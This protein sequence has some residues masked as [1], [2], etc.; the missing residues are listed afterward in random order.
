MC[1]HLSWAMGGMNN[2]VVFSTTNYAALRS[3]WGF[4]DKGFCANI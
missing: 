4:R 3:G 1:G 2:Y